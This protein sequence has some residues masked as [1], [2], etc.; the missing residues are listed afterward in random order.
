MFFVCLF[1]DIVSITVAETSKSESIFDVG[2]LTPGTCP[3]MSPVLW[4]ADRSCFL[5]VIAACS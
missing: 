1:F 4:L 5:Y 3:L 2:I